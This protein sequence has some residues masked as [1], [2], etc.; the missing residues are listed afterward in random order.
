MVE[1]KD[2]NKLYKYFVL[3]LVSAVDT[4]E[5]LDTYLCKCETDSLL[6]NIQYLRDRVADIKFDLNS[7]YDRLCDGGDDKMDLHKG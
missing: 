5:D 6:C 1:A 7:M 2:Y 3:D 4:I